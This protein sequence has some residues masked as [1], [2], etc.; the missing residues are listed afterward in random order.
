MIT[1]YIILKISLLHIRR[2]HNDSKNIQY[3]HNLKKTVHNHDL[4]NLHSYILK[5]GYDNVRRSNV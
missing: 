5:S 2:D 4:F 1:N 3:N